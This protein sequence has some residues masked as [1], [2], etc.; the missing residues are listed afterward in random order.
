MQLIEYMID[1]CE[2]EGERGEKRERSLHIIIAPNQTQ[3]QDRIFIFA[4]STGLG[5]YLR[6]IENTITI[7][8]DRSFY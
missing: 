5:G 2:G 4:G 6:F 8:I 7:Y 3:N 1:I